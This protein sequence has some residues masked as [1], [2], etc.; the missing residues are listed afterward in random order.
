MKFLFKIALMLTL[1][2]LAGAAAVH[3]QEVKVARVVDGDTV[4]LTAPGATTVHKARLIGMDAPEA[5]ST[6]YGHPEPG[7][8]EATETLRDLLSTA[9][10]VEVEYDTKREDRYGRDLVYLWVTDGT[11]NRV[12]VNAEMVRLGAAKAVAYPPNLLYQE[13]ICAGR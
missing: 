10:K 11:G 6:R 4:W 5:S 8:V 12:L 2:A 1:V 3:L 9:V 13:R 7:G